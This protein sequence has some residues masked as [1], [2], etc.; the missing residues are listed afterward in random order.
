MGS[1]HGSGVGGCKNLKWWH[2]RNVNF[3]RGKSRI[4]ITFRGT[5]GILSYILVEV[6]DGMLPNT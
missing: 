6:D 3:S 1:V 2:V 5:Q 4:S